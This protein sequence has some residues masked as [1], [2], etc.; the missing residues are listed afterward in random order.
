MICVCINAV[1]AFQNMN[2]F[3]V[4]FCSK[5]YICS[6]EW[7]CTM[8][9]HCR[10]VAKSRPPS[11]WGMGAAECSLVLKTKMTLQCWKCFGTYVLTCYLLPLLQLFVKCWNCWSGN[12]CFGCR[13][14][15]CCHPTHSAKTLNDYIAGI[16]KLPV[17][18]LII[19]QFVLNLS[20]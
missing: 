9:L 6:T 17:D 10:F 1:P 7:Q 4:V 5:L 15:L 18:F 13:S 14:G 20:L 12:F 2:D 19:L 16:N 11:W 8:H 3:S